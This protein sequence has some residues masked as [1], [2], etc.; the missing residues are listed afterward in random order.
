SQMKK[1][2][3]PK[4]YAEK[5]AA[6][7]KVDQ[8]I[9][10]VRKEMSGATKEASSFKDQLASLAK[11][12]AGGL[13]GAGAFYGF[14]NGAKTMIQKNAELSDSMAGVMKTTG[15]SEEAVDR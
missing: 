3:N 6:I 14:I 9:R 15:L 5:A 12:A 1:S 2:D 10:D 4:L 7:K 8:A 13:I 11:N